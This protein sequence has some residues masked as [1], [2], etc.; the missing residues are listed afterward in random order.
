MKVFDKQWFKYNQRVLLK[1]ANSYVGRCIL[2]IPKKHKY[3][4]G[5][6]PSGYGFVDHIDVN[7]NV[8]T[9]K[10]NFY[11]TNKM[12]YLLSSRLKYVWNTIH[13]I[14]W[15]W[16]DRQ[17]LIPSFG[18]DTYDFETGASGSS[19]TWDTRYSWYSGDFNF[20]ETWSYLRNPAN[21]LQLAVNSSFTS[22]VVG[23]NITPSDPNEYI[24]INRYGMIFDTVDAIDVLTNISGITLRL[25]PYSI[26]EVSEFWTTNSYN[27]I[28]ICSFTPDDDTNNEDAGDT[29]NFGSSSLAIFGN[30]N[31]S[32]WG[33]SNDVYKTVSL[34]VSDFD[35][36]SKTGLGI[37]L[38]GDVTNTEPS[39][40]YATG[41]KATFRDGN[42]AS[43]PR[44]QVT[45]EYPIKINIGDSWKDVNEIY[46]NIGDS[47]KSVT[48]LNINVL[49]V[50][51][52]T[53]N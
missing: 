2:E 33:L 32:T 44:L 7:K 24:T 27:D 40:W 10:Y 42:S 43:Q 4:V 26:S 45:Y 52:D 50:W 38:R 23:L 20:G 14:D 15:L 53:A 29:Y 35:R 36:D 41:F 46:I 13:F 11:T 6:D 9:C 47:W 49:D 1:F 19:D 22:R 3:V 51:K 25:K 28:V 37:A 16:L 5:I 30:W 31:G 12:A 48:D 17:S 21:A 18:F 34:S 39:N 8:M